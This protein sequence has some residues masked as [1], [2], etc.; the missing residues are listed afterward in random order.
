[1][2]RSSQS[3]ESAQGRTGL[4]FR[5]I[6][7]AAVVCAAI[8]LVGAG[9]A[10]ADNHA[11]D[12]ADH[13][14]KGTVVQVVTTNIQGKNVFIPSTIAVKKGAEV[15]LSIFNTTDTPHG[16]RITD[17][18]IETLLMPGEETRVE[19]PKL[20]EEGLHDIDCQLHPAHRRATLLVVD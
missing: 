13:A 12:H 6:G 3:A 11:H 15:T 14:D 8:W 10:G 18:G 9:S 20:E 16:F 7:S 2:E 17:L 19:L 1:M 5:T 4:G